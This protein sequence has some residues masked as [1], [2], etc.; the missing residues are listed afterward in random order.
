MIFIESTEEGKKSFF[1]IKFIYTVQRPMV[2]MANELHVCLKL[3]AQI[4]V[5][6]TNGGQP[7]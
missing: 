3:A 5:L 1:S 2:G 4:S 6:K 7:P